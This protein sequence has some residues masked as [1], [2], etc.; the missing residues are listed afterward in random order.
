MGF[1]DPNGC[2]AH[3]ETAPEDVVVIFRRCYIAGWRLLTLIIDGLAVSF[4][5]AGVLL[6]AAVERFPFQKLVLGYLLDYDQMLYQGQFMVGTELWST[7]PE[8]GVRNC[9][10]LL[11]RMSLLNRAAHLS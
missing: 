6:F 2:C 9:P 5:S 4:S 1:V 3:M 7:T 10:T 11:S 8:R